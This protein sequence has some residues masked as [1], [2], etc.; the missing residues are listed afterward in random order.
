[1]R[2]IFWVIL[3]LVVVLVLGLGLLVY[4]FVALFGLLFANWLLVRYAL[5]NVAVER[6]SSRDRAEIGETVEVTLSLTNTGRYPVVWCIVEDLLSRHA[7]LPPPARLEVRGRRV[8]LLGLK[9]GMRTSICYGLECRGRG[10]FQIGPA[11][12]ETGDLFGLF[13]RWRVVTRPEYLTVYP[14]LL[15]IEGFDIASRRP[16]GEIR[17]THRLYQDPTRLAGIRDYHPGDSLRQIHWRATARTGRLQSK[18]YEPSS[19]AGATLV[20][21]FHRESYPDSARAELGIVCAASLA[22]AICAQQQQVGLVTNGRDAAE[23]IRTEGWEVEYRSRE[24]AREAA[25]MRPRSDRLAPVIVPTVRSDT[26]LNRILEVLARL[27]LSDGLSVAQT[28]IEA[29]PHLPRDATVVVIVPTAYEATVA[30]LAALRQGGLAITV[31]INT[32]EPHDYAVM[33]GKFLEY[34][35]EARHLRDKAGI[36]QLC[37]P[38]VLP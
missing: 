33:A 13:R 27:E 24:E 26:Q 11:I 19:V 15:P 31:I 30:T 28:V 21:D 4:A 18:L 9:P 6:R 20:L 1:M 38:Y 8:Q 14:E 16:I 5:R 25:Q 32:Y 17:M 7:L 23:R 12:L 29:M 37:Q 35:I 34:G 36:T 2:W 22:A 10:F 3:A